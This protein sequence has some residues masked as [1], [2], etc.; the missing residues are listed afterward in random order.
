MLPLFVLL[1]MVLSEL[2]HIMV[3]YISNCVVCEL[4]FPSSWA[5]PA[6][7]ETDPE[8]FQ[9]ALTRWRHDR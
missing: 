1:L 4:H 8:V 6:G 7:S 9:Q 5:L 3:R 2:R